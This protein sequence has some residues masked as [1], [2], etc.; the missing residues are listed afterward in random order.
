MNQN[1]SYQLLL[2]LSYRKA[3]NRE[4][5]FVSQSNEIAVNMV[6]NYPN[7]NT[8]ALIIIG[9]K[10]CGKTHLCHVLKERDKNIKIFENID[11]NI[12]EEILFHQLNRLNEKVLITTKISPVN[13]KIKS[14]DLKS[15][16]NAQNTVTIEN[17]DDN[18]IN[19]III[20]QFIDRGILPKPHV[21][22]Y[23]AKHS[24]RSFNFLS[25]LIGEISDK[26]VQLKRK[27]TISFV[28]EILTN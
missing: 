23:I 24:E 25:K 26:S 15:R 17:P 18:L 21:I 8:P 7:W 13:L 16:L 28:K 11:E 4:N 2:P 19:A 10:E 20:K 22:K 14:P 3:Y 5:F 6:D 1:N 9:P 12:N 27:I